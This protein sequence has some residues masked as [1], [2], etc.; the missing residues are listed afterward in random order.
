MILAINIIWNCWDYLIFPLST[1]Y[2]ALFYRIY[3][4]PFEY[5]WLENSVI[6]YQIESFNPELIY[7][8]IMSQCMPHP[9]LPPI[10]LPSHPFSCSDAPLPSQL[11]F[12]QKAIF[13]SAFALQQSFAFSSSNPFLK[14]QKIVSKVMT[15]VNNV[16]RLDKHQLIFNL[17]GKGEIKRCLCFIC[18]YIKLQI[19]TQAFF[20]EWLNRT[21]DS[22]E[23]LVEFKTM[24]MFACRNAFYKLSKKEQHT[25]DS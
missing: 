2:K 24:S 11:P 17:W 25:W 19:Y 7:I 9:L 4:I 20:W 23:I 8:H 10:I 22:A 18:Q 16:I 21:F 15:P 1:I 12:H 3:K 14:N 13:F 6:S 5:I